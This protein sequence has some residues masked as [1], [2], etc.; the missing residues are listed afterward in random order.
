MDEATQAFYARYAQQPAANEAA[1]SAMAAH[2]ASS[3]EPGAHVLDV[4]AGLGRDVLAL[5]ELGFDGW[6]V[7]PCQAMREQALVRHPA[8]SGRLAD[9]GLPGLGRP[10]GRE[11]WQGV[12]CSAVLMHLPPQQMSAAM[13]AMVDLLDAGGRLLLSL[14]QM[15]EDRIR[16]DR[17]P[18][19][20][21][22]F[23]HSPQAMKALMKRLGLELRGQ[24]DSHAVWEQAGTVWI[25]QCYE[26]MPARAGL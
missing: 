3:F 25:T 5:L 7:E 23:N 19:G 13:T 22:F 2:F 12:V 8:L 21:L 18:Q 10:F 4:G 9:A 17:D 24:W 15:H 11:A 20:R 16:D 26:R 6:G 14:A 1:R